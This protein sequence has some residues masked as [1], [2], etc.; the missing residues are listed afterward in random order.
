MGGQSP[1]RRRGVAGWWISL[2]GLVALAA[3]VSAAQSIPS[4]QTGVAGTSP[5]R[6]LFPPQSTVVLLLGVPG[7]LESENKYREQ[8]EAWLEWV[9]SS[10]QVQ[11]LYVLC[12]RPESVSSPEKLEGQVLKADRTTFL[13]LGPALAEQTNSLVVIAWGHGGRQGNAA[14][15]HVRGPRLT[16][17]D[18]KE[19]ASRVPQADSRW[20]LMFR[21]SGV[22][23]SALAGER[24][25]VLASERDTMFDSDPVG[26]GLLLK[27]VRA[28]PGLSFE[29]LSEQ[30]GRATAAWYNE[31]NLARTEEPTLWAGNEPPRPLAPAAD[32]D[33]VADAHPKGAKDAAAK[34]ET[35][36]VAT[37]GPANAPE[38]EGAKQL[39]TNLPASWIGIKRVEAQDYADADGVVLRQRLN[40]TLAGSPAIVS[41]QEEFIQILT[42]EG[43]R[44]GDFD[45]SYSPPLEDITFMDC[46]VL[47]PEGKLVRLDPDAI[48]ESRESSV[49]DYQAGRRKFFSLPGV[50][51]GAVLH[52]RYRTQWQKFPL[53]HVSLQI[54]TGHQ[55][56]VAESTIQVGVPK[57]SAF[58]FA[59]EQMA[60]PDPLIQ[61]AGYGTTYSW[62][63]AN[64]PAQEREILGPPG[65][66]PRLLIS[67]FPDWAA[68][69]E[70]YGRISKLTDEV[71]PELAAKAAELARD[72][73]NDRAKVLAVYNYVTAL[74]YV[75]VPLGVNSYR[76]HAAANVLQ[77]QFGDCKD[78]ANLCNALL[79]SLQIEAHLVLVPRFGQAREGLSGLAFNHAISR[80]GLG[81][82]TLW[83][84]TTDDVCRFG[85]LPPGDPGRKVLVVDGQTSELTQL[86]A[87]E[88]SEHVLMLNGQMNCSGPSGAWPISLNAV[89]RGYPDYEL[90]SAARD[91]KE[92]RASLPLL[93]TRFRPVTGAF[94]LEKQRA[95]A[96]SALDENFT[97]QA[98]GTCVG[99]STVTEGKWRVHSPFWLPK[100]WDL[101]LHQRKAPLFLNQGYPLTLEEEIDFTLPS[102]AQ[103]L[104]LP[105]VVESKAEPLR[106]RI[107]WKKS[108]QD[109][110]TACFRAELARGELS[111][112]DTPVLQQ[113]LRE[114][115][116]ALAASAT[117]SLPP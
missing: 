82:E 114:L 31:R 12:D 104:A 97:W 39:G 66:Q 1:A 5:A 18:F 30:L 16:A 4:V 20:I 6:T 70:W 34:A 83:V 92:H 54:P 13:N 52:V 88:P 77:N 17:A 55:L 99:N 33:S 48:R 9:A 117:V 79:H 19:L 25:Q 86:P 56:P 103:P 35:P 101:A 47:L 75:A 100:E 72:A 95:T 44:F 59:F 110:L 69:A 8:L 112:S 46:E 91:A 107:E 85:L 108:G 53:P 116:G 38:R 42:P 87:P 15:F 24:R 64:L 43:K 40:Y 71:T 41:D 26:M 73:K 62:H 80:V 67:T 10:G 63:L 65:Q 74:R 81:G 84:D 68:F 21:G 106:W 2:L 94:A 113:Q 111:A 32:S 23:A 60:A 50:G 22:F 45:I 58:H 51:P 98:E 57:A 115:L 102:R 14:V 61:Q 36:K 76:P 27:Q 37:A 28:E 96:V 105:G 109:K 90:R 78:K 11:K 93:A 89:A 29:A 3:G 7:D 49:G